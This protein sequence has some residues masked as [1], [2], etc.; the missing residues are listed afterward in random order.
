M[1]ID[2]FDAIIQ[3]LWIISPA[4]PLRRRSRSAQVHAVAPRRARAQA[5]QR[6]KERVQRGLPG[7]RAALRR[8]LA[9]Q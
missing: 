8:V 3:H 7:D 1:L 2:F 4:S 5:R 6:R 9:R